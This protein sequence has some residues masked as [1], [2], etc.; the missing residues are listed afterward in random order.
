MKNNT[1]QSLLIIATLFTCAIII[2]IIN[3]KHVINQGTTSS[4][5]LTRKPEAGPYAGYNKN[6][7]NEYKKNV[8]SKKFSDNNH[9]KRNQRLLSAISASS[10]EQVHISYGIPAISSMVV[11]WA[12]GTPPTAAPASSVHYSENIDDIKNGKGST[13]NVNCETPNSYKYLCARSGLP[14]CKTEEYQSPYFHHCTISNLKTNTKYF[15]QVGPYPTGSTPPS[16]PF[17]FRTARAVGDDGNGVLTVSVIGDM[18]Q[19]PYSEETRDAVKEAMSKD[20]SLQ[21]GFILGDMSYADGDNNRWDTWGRMMESMLANLPTMYMVGNHEIEDDKTT[22][23]SFL[24]YRNRFRMPSTLKE[25]D[26]PYAYFP[27]LPH[28]YYNLDLTYDGGSS[29]YSFSVGLAHF[30]V[31]NTYNT[32]LSGKGSPQYNFLKTDL[33][34]IDRSKTPWVFVFMHGPFYQS[35][36]VHQDEHATLLLQ[37]WAEPLFNQYHVDAVFAG[38]VHA[39]QRTHPI[40]ANAGPV[41]VTVGDGGNREKLYDKFDTETWSAYHNGDHY[42]YGNIRVYSKDKAGWY[43]RGNPDPNL[44]DVE[45]S[46]LFTPHEQRIKD[47]TKR[48]QDQ[49]NVEGIIA[50]TL[51]FTC[52]FCAVFVI[53]YRYC[54]NYVYGDGN[55]AKTY[56]STALDDSFN[57]DLDSTEM[58]A[59]H[60]RYKSP[61]FRPINVEDGSKN[62]KN[63]YDDVD[64]LTSNDI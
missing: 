17:S 50:F 54:K 7:A 61:D 39:Y 24:P 60:G 13:S 3:N 28:H 63:P 26:G 51:F 5:K 14:F 43:W 1:M 6:T 32:H 57:T 9:N 33:E 52:T 49:K 15:Y 8:L 38:H 41:Y 25:V 12:A 48:K 31:L 55:M 30:I 64:Q 22:K 16:T 11:S 42:G 27:D 45:D 10:P 4:R 19:T 40:P 21:F 44:P 46:V 47:E 59:E 20:D 23:M 36:E 37:S 34:S 56:N 62:N 2:V 58:L 29:Y 35:N 18:G 53:T